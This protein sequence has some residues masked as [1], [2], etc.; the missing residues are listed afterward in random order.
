MYRGNSNT[1]TVV[2][3]PPLT[4]ALQTIGQLS[5][6]KTLEITFKGCG[7]ISKYVCI[8]HIKWL[9]YDMKS[10]IHAQYT[11][12]LHTISHVNIHVYSTIVCPY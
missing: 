6:I 7:G 12:L 8:S 5:T 4:H 2:T 1:G 10:I 9:H 11:T 3:M